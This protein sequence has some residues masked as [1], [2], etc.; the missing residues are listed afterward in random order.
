ML[1]RL[2]SLQKTE[3][4]PDN[5]NESDEY[6]IDYSHN[7]KGYELKVLK[8]DDSV[9]INLLV[10]PSRYLTDR[11]SFSLNDSYTLQKKS[12]SQ[13]ATVQTKIDHHVVNYKNDFER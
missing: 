7:S 5:W 2:F 11:R 1:S 3:V 9:I 10:R 4:L 12:S 8:S 13:T 6:T